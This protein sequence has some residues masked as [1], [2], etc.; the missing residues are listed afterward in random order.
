MPAYVFCL[1]YW[2]RNSQPVRMCFMQQGSTTVTKTESTV[3]WK[4]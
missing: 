3:I 4:K 2:Q 1:E